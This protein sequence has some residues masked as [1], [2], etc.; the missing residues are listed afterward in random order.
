MSSNANSI[1]RSLTGAALVLAAAFLL[2]GAALA[3]PPIPPGGQH[4]VYYGGGNTQGYPPIQLS[5]TGPDMTDGLA[6]LRVTSAPN[7][8]RQV[9]LLQFAARRGEPLRV[10]VYD[11]HGRLRRDLM[12]RAQSTGRQGIGWDGRDTSGLLLPSGVYFYTVDAGNRST[13]GRLVFLR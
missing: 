12:S 6:T 3:A 11:T 10:R 5:D 7:P 4:A 13:R 8:F 9:T 2:S 1:R